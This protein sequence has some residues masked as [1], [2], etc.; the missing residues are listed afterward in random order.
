MSSWVIILISG[1]ALAAFGGIL[2]IWAVL[3]RRGIIEVLVRQ[4]ANRDVKDLLDDRRISLGPQSLKIGGWVAIAVGVV[5]LI[6]G[7]VLR[8][9]G[10]A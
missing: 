10:Q 7:L 3:E 6:L 8:A 4:D 2:F 1:G 5:L 9:T